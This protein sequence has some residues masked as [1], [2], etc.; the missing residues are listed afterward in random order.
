MPSRHRPLAEAAAAVIVMMALAVGV[1]AC[2]AGTGSS[3]A[4]GAAPSGSVP[5][6]GG[7]AAGKSDRGP[8]NLPD[9]ITV[10][11]KGDVEG[12]PDTLHVTFGV[13]VRRD[14]VDQAVGDAANEATAM[15][16]AVQASGVEE[17]DIQTRDYRIQQEFKYLPNA[18]PVPDGYRVTNTLVMK[19][20]AL[21]KAG[22]VIDAA[23]KAGGND[24]T[25]QGVA[26]SLE[27]DETALRTAREKAFADARSRAEQYA[28][29]SG[30][31][32]GRAEAVSDVVVRATPLA[33]TGQ[34]YR[35]EDAAGGAAS[36]PVQAGQ[37]TTTVTVS[38]RFTFA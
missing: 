3:P 33:Y 34:A 7:G 14:T 18:S 30:Q 37:V 31:S 5:G 15:I 13:S 6:G 35:A 8:D 28:K 10:E 27:E 17:K 22:S 24:A 36:T 29:L 4:G 26:F 1:A 9:G 25:L 11:G 23:T 16:A 20:R 12:K 21:D 2:S 38:V 19:V 32:L